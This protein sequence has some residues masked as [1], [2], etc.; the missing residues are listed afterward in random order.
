[1]SSDYHKEDLTVDLTWANIFG[2]IVLIPSILFFGLPF[3]LIWKG[4]LANG[5]IFNTVQNISGHNPLLTSL[6][7]ILLLL[8]GVILH[9]LIHGV[10][11]AFYAEEKFKSIKFGITRNWLSLYCHCKEPVKVYQYITS[12]LMPAIILG[13]IPSILSLFIGD[14]ILLSF[15]ICLIAAASGDFLISYKL[16]KEKFDD[17]V[18]DHPEKAGCY[19]FRKK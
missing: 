8:F 5:I 2:F 1:M 3:Y 10:F 17:Y 19:I 12:G 6:I 11:F 7:T 13:F 4:Q 14:T 15:G 16:R 9:E 18:Q